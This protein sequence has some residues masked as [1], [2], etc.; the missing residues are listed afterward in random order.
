M[1]IV[2][3][4]FILM[5]SLALPG[6]ATTDRLSPDNELAWVLRVNPNLTRPGFP[7]KTLD[8][9]LAYYGYSFDYDHVLNFT[10]K[11]PAYDKATGLLLHFVKLRVKCWP[12]EITHY[13]IYASY[14]VNPANGSIMCEKSIAINKEE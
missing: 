5:F 9:C 12:N 2:I 6:L 11:P 4:T 14:L 10:D 7:L 8:S 3:L 1:K 13:Y